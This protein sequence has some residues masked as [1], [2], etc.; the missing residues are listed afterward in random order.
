MLGGESVPNPEACSYKGTSTFSGINNSLEGNPAQRGSWFSEPSSEWDSAPWQA[1]SF[2]VTIQSS[3]QRYVSMFMNT[4]VSAKK[5]PCAT[6]WRLVIGIKREFRAWLTIAACRRTL[7]CA[8]ACQVIWSLSPA[9]SIHRRIEVKAK[10]WRQSRSKR[11]CLFSSGAC[12][13]QVLID[14]K[15]KVRKRHATHH[16]AKLSLS[17]ISILLMV[18]C[19]PLF[20]LF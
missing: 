10:S 17:F 12:E 6:R 8:E 16:C 4:E 19:R 7:E 20:K 9:W 5:S 3:Q 13:G 11:C 18:L 15:L 2:T 14:S 1:A